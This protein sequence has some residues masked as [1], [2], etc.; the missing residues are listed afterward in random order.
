MGYVRKSVV[1]ILAQHLKKPEKILAIEGVRQTGKTTAIRQAL[2]GKLS[3]LITLTD[4]TPKVALVRDATTF[5]DFKHHL[6]SQYGFVCNGK[7]AL[8]IDEAQKSPELHRFVMQMER[9][10]QN[11]PIIFAGS[12]MGAFFK[13]STLSDMPSVAGR[14]RR[15]ICR[16]FSF[17][18]FVDWIGES[19]L[20]DVVANHDFTRAFPIEV[21][22]RLMT[23]FYDY[24]T[25]GGMPEAIKKRH[26]TQVLYDYFE[27][28]LSFFWQDTD[29][30]LSEILQT[31]KHQFGA[32]FHHVL[33]A[34][35]RLTTQSSTRTSLVSSDS[36]S[37]RTELP[38]LLNAAEEWHFL[39]R[40]VTE[41]KSLTTKTGTS[42]KKYLWDVGVVNHFLNLSRQVSPQSSPDLL[43]R[44]LESFVAQELIFK[45]KNRERLATWKSHH[46]MGKEMDFLAHFPK[47][48]IGIEVK[49]AKRISQKSISQLSEFLKLDTPTVGFVVY[50]GLPER[51]KTHSGVIHFIPPYFLAH[52]DFENSRPLLA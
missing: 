45:L 10:W 44:L 42:S 15:V 36:P 31:R 41:M 47:N 21:H 11:V 6:Q 48:D 4:A 37:Y 49:A 24:L 8:V 50:L 3:L 35:A 14:V 28:L 12:V 40:L 13:R 5:T 9:E 43:A 26:G 2:D 30:Y 39:F 34:V 32:L 17:F 27:T 33:Q 23:L 16:P 51:L 38:A 25:C 20:L 22:E 7:T 1:D 18:E 46:K 29:R 19:S 52:P